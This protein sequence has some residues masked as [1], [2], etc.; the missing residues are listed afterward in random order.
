MVGKHRTRRRNKKKGGGTRRNKRGS[1]RGG[2]YGE[3]FSRSRKYINELKNAAEELNN[4]ESDPATLIEIWNKLIKDTVYTK[5]KVEFDNEIQKLFYEIN[6]HRQNPLY[7]KENNVITIDTDSDYKKHIKALNDA[8]AVFISKDEDFPDDLNNIWNSIIKKSDSYKYDQQEFIEAMNSILNEINKI[9]FLTKKFYL[10]ANN[11]IKMSEYDLGAAAKSDYTNVI[12]EVEEDDTSEKF[13]TPVFVPKIV[14][15]A[16]YNMSYMS[17]KGLPVDSFE[18]QKSS[19]GAFLARLSDNDRTY[20]E[21]ALKLL[22]RFFYEHKNTPCIIGLQ[23]INQTTKGSNTGSDA[24]DQMLIRNKYT[25]IKN[26]EYTGYVQ[27]CEEVPKQIP[28]KD[29]PEMVGISIIYNQY[30]LGKPLHKGVYD[31]EKKGRP[32]LI[33]FTEKGYLF[34]NTHGENVGENPENPKNPENDNYDFEVLYPFNNHVRSIVFNKINI[35]LNTF[36]NDFKIERNRE[37]I[38]HIFITGDLNDRF[39]A[40]DEI[41]LWY[42]DRTVKY[43][44]DAPRSCCYNWDSACPDSDDKHERN[45]KYIP[46]KNIDDSHTEYGYC[47]VPKDDNVITEANTKNPEQ[48]LKKSMGDRGKKEFYRYRGDK[49]FGEYPLTE[50]AIFDNTKKAI[51]EESDHQMVFAKFSLSPVPAAQGG[52]KRKHKT[53][54]VLKKKGQRKTSTY[55]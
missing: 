4:N 21:N 46:F 51:S 2:A 24:I 8:K 9:K 53:R 50:I 22:N 49:V 35:N 29:E 28:G 11:D 54:K 10:D 40:I 1:K 43:D 39:D 7:L 20:W 18:R 55:V 26:N 33:V 5:Y 47:T 15:V 36:L 30:I 31:N 6:K 42:I 52:R 44:G 27:I 17:D 25:V 48:R 3:F 13:D 34:I 12:P 32:T 37:T 23:E 16:S 45:H 14:T 38:K 41:T 19:E